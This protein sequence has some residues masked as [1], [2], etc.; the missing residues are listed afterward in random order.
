[1]DVISLNIK[2]SKLP[3]L[4][5]TSKVRWHSLHSFGKMRLRNEE[6]RMYA[7]LHRVEPGFDAS[8]A[9]HGGDSSPTQGAQG[10]QTCRDREVSLHEKHKENRV[11]WWYC[12]VENQEL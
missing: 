2:S 9:F 4:V 8:Y 6:V 10:H 1:M 5:V 11:K 12:P 3:S 7:Y